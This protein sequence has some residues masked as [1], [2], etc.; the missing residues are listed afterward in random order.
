LAILKTIDM[1]EEYEKKKRQRMAL[2]RSLMDYGIGT[3]IIG[4]GLFFFFR[5]YFKIPFNETFPPDDIDIFFGAMCL[6]YGIW[7]IYRGYK[8]NYFK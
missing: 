3:L 7:R 5:K 6:V 4:A 2:M 8:K 1:L